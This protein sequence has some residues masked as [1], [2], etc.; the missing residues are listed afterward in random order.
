MTTREFPAFTNVTRGFIVFHHF[1]GNVFFL[2]FLPCY[3]FENKNLLRRQ[4]CR[5][6]QELEQELAVALC[7]P[8]F[9]Y[10]NPSIKVV[11]LFII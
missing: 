6:E 11:I 9:S 8:D 3:H 5:Q 7:C 2:N 4:V 1:S 10:T